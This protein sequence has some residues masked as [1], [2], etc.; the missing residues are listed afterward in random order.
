MNINLR[1]Y[2]RSKRPWF[3]KVAV[4]AREELSDILRAVEWI[5]PPEMFA[6]FDANQGETVVLEEQSV[7][8]ERFLSIVFAARDWQS[9]ESAGPDAVGQLAAA[10]AALAPPSL[11]K[12]IK[13]RVHGARHRADWPVR[14]IRVRARADRRLHLVVMLDERLQEDRFME[15]YETLDRALQNARAGEVTG[16]GFGL[17]GWNLD[18]SLQKKPAGKNILREELAKLPKHISSR[19]TAEGTDEPFH[20]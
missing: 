14:R 16:S 9:V 2:D 13:E 4:R 17:G 3:G 15:L 12:R 10:V 8:G 20:L 19:V 5:D 18:V 6:G 11:A 7:G 1:G